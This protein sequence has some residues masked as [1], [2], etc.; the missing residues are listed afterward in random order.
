MTEQFCNL[1]GMNQVAEL[2]A[3]M[4]RERTARGWS[5]TELARRA[6]IHAV[7]AGAS[8]ISQQSVSGFETDKTKKR[9]PDWVIYVEKAFAEPVTDLPQSNVVLAPDAP[10]LPSPL[11]MPQDIPVMGTVS[12][13]DGLEIVLS[14][15]VLMQ[16][17]RPPGLKGRKGIFAL[18]TQGESM[19]PWRRPGQ[20]VYVDPHK[21]PYIGDH[22]LVEL[23][24]TGPDGDPQHGALLKRLVK[25]NSEFVCLAQYNP[26]REDIKIQRKKIV[27]ILRV[28]EL[29]ELM[30]V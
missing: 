13:G 12:G 5:T 18:F 8:E 26:P 16:A 24:P 3:W 9:R 28:I 17:P 23:R 2:Q 25:L 19:V 30:G 27:R 15:E 7:A 29:D 20:I 14:G 10:R 6:S 1:D 22:V 21:A 11:E 4:R